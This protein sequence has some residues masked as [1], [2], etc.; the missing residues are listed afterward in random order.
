LALLHV[1]ALQFQAPH[2]RELISDIITNQ[3]PPPASNNKHQTSTLSTKPTSN[4]HR[5]RKEKSA[6]ANTKTRFN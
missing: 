4:T 5:A 1:I 3:T 6:F 2:T